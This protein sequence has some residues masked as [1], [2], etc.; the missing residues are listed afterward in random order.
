MKQ[1][2]LAR[3]FLCLI[4]LVTIFCNAPSGQAATEK[5]KLTT[6]DGYRIAGILSRPSQGD[7]RLGVVLLPMYR[8]I[9][10]SW[11][12]LVAELD[13]RGLVS[14]AI[15]MRGHGESRIGPDG[16]DSGR[17]MERDPALFNAMH[18]D[19]EA[20]VRYLIDQAGCRKIGLVGASVGC[21]VAIDTAV[22]AQVPVAAVVVMTPGSDYLGIPTLQQ[23]TGWPGDLP[24]L[25]LSSAEEK[26]RGAEAISRKLAK[27]RAELVLFDQT[28]IHGTNMFGRVDGVAERIV[29]WLNGKLQ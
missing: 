28:N 29:N 24:L 27:Q 16:D 26:E 22:R 10:E 4:S 11:Q 12:P 17:V 8:H 7:G 19:A 18:L 3:F 1:R 20:A 9:K 13:R 2:S 6:A 21:S 23:I 25:I 5:V 15:D 14:L